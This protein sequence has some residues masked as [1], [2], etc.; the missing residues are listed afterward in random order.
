MTEN[1]IITVM[2]DA[3][4]TGLAVCAPVLL[5]SVIIGLL[6]SIFQAT[7]QIQEQTLTFLPK[8]LAVVLVGFMTG[9]WML[10]MMT[11]FMNRI[12]DMISNITR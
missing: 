2:K 3:V 1:M 12:F 8:L 11:G 9:S 6:I 4:S 5:V 10:H 7:T